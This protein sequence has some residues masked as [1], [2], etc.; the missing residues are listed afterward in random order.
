MRYFP[1][2]I[3]C[4]NEVFP[5]SPLCKNIGL[6]DYCVN[7]SADVYFINHLKNYNIY[8][9]LVVFSYRYRLMA[10]AGTLFYSRINK[11]HNFIKFYDDFKIDFLNLY[12]KNRYNINKNHPISQLIDISKERNDGNCYYCGAYEIDNI[13]HF[14]PEGQEDSKSGKYFP[15]LCVMSYNLVPSCGVCNRKKSTHVGIYATNTFIHPYFSK[16]LDDEF[17]RCDVLFDRTLKTITFTYSIELPP[18][19]SLLN[20]KRL[21]WQFDR[22]DLFMRYSTKAYGNLKKVQQK[23]KETLESDGKQ[24]L[25]DQLVS[26]INSIDDYLGVNNWESV[27]YVALINKLNDFIFFLKNIPSAPPKRYINPLDLGKI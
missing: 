10:S 22:L 26:E 9:D 16:F 27:M 15:Q 13:D 25:Y 5:I 17:L 24:A 2:P 19:W 18:S 7:R 12:K 6:F 20:K 8:N 3:L 11:H 23:Y 14:L 4:N 1:E 21:L